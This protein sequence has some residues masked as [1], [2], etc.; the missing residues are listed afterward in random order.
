[1]QKPM[2]LKVIKT[3]LLTASMSLLAVGCEP[4]PVPLPDP[5]VVPDPDF[6]PEILFGAMSSRVLVDMADTT[7]SETAAYVLL[8]PLLT[9]FKRNSGIK[10]G[11]KYAMPLFD[12]EMVFEI[13]PQSGSSVFHFKGTMED[14][15]GWMNVYYDQA[16]KTFT[17]DQC[18]FVDA[19]TVGMYVAVYAEGHNI[20]V[21]SNG[22]Y[23]DLYDIAYI[24]N[25]GETWEL[26]TLTAEMYR[27]VMTPVGAVGTGFGFY[28]DQDSDYLAG[29]RGYWSILDDGSDLPSTHPTTISA[30]NLAEWEAILSSDDVLHLDND[31]ESWGIHFKLDGFLSPSSI[32]YS[33]VGTFDTITDYAAGF[34]TNSVAVDLSTWGA[35]SLLV[36]KIP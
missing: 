4:D 1:M 24:L 35:A 29:T 8:G 23:N 22:Y 34:T 31:E 28:C 18:I 2:Y 13:I 15:S 20:L 27:G 32:D 12:S 21:D 3:L 11:S 26:V 33:S 9:N 6:L 5:I 7:Q 36:K 10:S 25:S 30:A 16:A 17:F 14:G 19:A